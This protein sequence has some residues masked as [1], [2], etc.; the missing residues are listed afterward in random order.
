MKSQP[1]SAPPLDPVGLRELDAPSLYPSAPP[2]TEKT[3]ASP[4]G[5]Q[6][7]SRL[8]RARRFGTGAKL[9]LF[10]GLITVLGIGGWA[11]YRYIFAGDAIRA[12]LVLHKFC[13]GRLLGTIV[14]RG[15][16]RSAE[17][18]HITC[19]AQAP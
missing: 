4:N 5:Q 9:A 11:S 6:T 7:P 18:K 2:L 15:R 10:A 14:E 1:E 17:H 12:D 3:A 19:K 8:P 13:R 16:L